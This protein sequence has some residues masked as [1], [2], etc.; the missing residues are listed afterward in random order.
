[1]NSSGK[2]FLLA[3]LVYASA[4]LLVTAA[5]LIV[6]R[7]FL[8]E[9]EYTRPNTVVAEFMNGLELDGI[10]EAARGTV[11]SLNTTLMPE[12]ECYN[13]LLTKLRESRCAKASG[14]CSAEKCVYYLQNGNLTLGRMVL[15]AGEKTRFGFSSWSVTRLELELDKLCGE[16]TLTVPDDYTLSC[17]GE[18]MRVGEEQRFSLLEEFYD[19]GEISS[20]PYLV[21]YGTGKY[22][23]E[24][25]ISVTRPDGEAYTGDFSEESFADN[26]TEEEKAALRDFVERFLTAYIRYSSNADR[27][28]ENNFYALSSLIVPGSQLQARMRTAMEG[29]IWSNSYGDSLSGIDYGVIMKL[30]GGNYFCVLQYSVDTYGGRGLVTTHNDIK[31]IVSE[32]E[33]GLL[34]LSMYSF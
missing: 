34:A 6:L 8:T 10:R 18:L 28:I 30:G 17:A 12:D 1:M 23:I 13:Y 21:T 11:E 33:A 15:S 7:G 3:M 14:E 2:R 25:E 29:L 22:L 19:D 24:P 27:N 9:Y 31:L 26:C 32:T 16:K 5:G 4:F 20:L